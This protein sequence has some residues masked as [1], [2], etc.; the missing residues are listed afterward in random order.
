[1][2]VRVHM[3]FTVFGDIF[4]VSLVCAVLFSSSVCVVLASLSLRAL[5][6]MQFILTNLFIMVIVETFEVSVP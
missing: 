2:Y 3:R 1:M 6:I 4:F 5:R